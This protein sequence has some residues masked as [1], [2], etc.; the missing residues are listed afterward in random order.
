MTFLP[1]KMSETLKKKADQ[2]LFNIAKLVCPDFEIDFTTLQCFWLS[3]TNLLIS[4]IRSRLR[5]CG[6]VSKASRD[7][8]FG[9]KKSIMKNWFI[10][11]ST[12][13]FPSATIFFGSSSKALRDFQLASLACCCLVI[14][15]YKRWLIISL[16]SLANQF[17]LSL[18]SK[19][20]FLCIRK[21]T[22]SSSIVRLNAFANYVANVMSGIRLKGRRRHKK[23]E[24]AHTECRRSDAI[25]KLK[26]F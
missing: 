20:F 17:S 19:F 8:R 15:A 14:S 18:C 7:I 2:K 25:G 6:E 16:L 10:N 12:S 9:W 21:I 11:R 4:I 5:R 23:R 13:T 22:F 26:S 24:R 1:Q 3:S